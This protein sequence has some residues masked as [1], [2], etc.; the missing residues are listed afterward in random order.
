MREVKIYVCEICNR[1]FKSE[2]EAVKCEN[3]G[4]EIPLTTKGQKV[5]YK[6]DWNGGFGE[7]WYETVV[8]NVITTGHF[9]EYELGDQYSLEDGEL[10][11]HPQEYIDGNKEFLERCKII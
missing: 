4:K 9:V 3:Q 1:E 10:V 11:F 8:G 5:S 7:Q 6:D 2:E